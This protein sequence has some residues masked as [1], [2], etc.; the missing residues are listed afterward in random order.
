LGAGPAGDV[1]LGIDL[2]SFL[3]LQVTGG[4]TFA[5]GRRPDYAHSLVQSYVAIGP[6]FTLP[7]DARWAVN[8]APSFAY[9][10][11]DD[12]IGAAASGAGIVAT[13]GVEYW[14]HVRHFSVGA[15]LNVQVPLAP[16]RLF[17]GI[18][19]HVRYTF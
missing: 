18:L 2:L 4:V 10:H 5:G 1:V 8:L 9:F 14:A 15:D 6:R 7:V 12:G 16:T 13:A 17:V 19:P 3:G 11:Q